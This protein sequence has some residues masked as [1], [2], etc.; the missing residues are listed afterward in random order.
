MRTL[1]S[2]LLVQWTT[3]KWHRQVPSLSNVTSYMSHHGGS[4]QKENH[5]RGT[6]MKFVT[7]VICGGDCKE[8]L[9][10]SFPSA[11]NA[12]CAPLLKQSTLLLQK[13]TKYFAQMMSHPQVGFFTSLSKSSVGNF[14]RREYQIETD[15]SKSA[16]LKLRKNKDRR[17]AGHDGIHDSPQLHLYQLKP[18]DKVWIIYYTIKFTGQYIYML[19]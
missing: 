8:D 15:E 6:N 2:Y 14:L 11:R 13:K 18:S 4:H 12:L 17:R 19:W 9:I 3:Q 1:L 10:Q 5:D 16:F 7:M